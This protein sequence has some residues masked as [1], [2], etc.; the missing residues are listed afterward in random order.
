M[1]TTR[2]NEVQDSCVKE[3]HTVGNTLH[4]LG[5]P[6]QLFQALADPTLHNY[7]LFL[8]FC[9]CYLLARNL[10]MNCMNLLFQRRSPAKG[11]M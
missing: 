2:Y 5:T 10:T 4:I 9:R 1:S 8:G 3:T 7:L 6:F 11:G